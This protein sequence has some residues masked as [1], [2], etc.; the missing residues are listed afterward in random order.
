MRK[1]GQ[2]ALRPC[3]KPTSKWKARTTAR[4]QWCYRCNG[5]AGVLRSAIAVLVLI[6]PPN[7]CESGMRASASSS[8]RL[9]M[10]LN[11]PIQQAEFGVQ[12]GVAYN[13]IYAILSPSLEV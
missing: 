4:M 8:G 13:A 5:S 1:A 6:E 12:R 11:R 7:P 9:K 2:D 10:G 3:C